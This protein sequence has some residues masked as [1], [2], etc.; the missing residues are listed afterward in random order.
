M[1]PFY[2]AER[3]VWLIPI[4]NEQADV[5]YRD[6]KLWY[7]RKDENYWDEDPSAYKEGS[8]FS[9]PSSYA[10]VKYAIE[11]DSPDDT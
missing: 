9:K 1:T 10:K 5:V 4:T 2:Y 7:S 6:A 3:G 8:T 11:V